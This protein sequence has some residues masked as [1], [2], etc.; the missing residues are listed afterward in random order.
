MAALQRRGSRTGATNE[1]RIA[2]AD[3][4]AGGEWS[5][6]AAVLEDQAWPFAVPQLAVNADGDAVAAWISN[7]GTTAWAAFRPAGG[8]WTAQQVSNGGAPKPQVAI[9]AAGDAVVVWSAGSFTETCAD[10]SGQR[11]RGSGVADTPVALGQTNLRER[12]VRD[13][14][15]IGNRCLVGQGGGYYSARTASM[16]TSNP[17]VWSTPETVSRVPQRRWW[18]P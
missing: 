18:E 5:P 16:S 2:F 1:L 4:P 14:P 8:T 6:P 10:P 13:G 9:T 12:V 7:A 11:R 17:W 3:R 15:G